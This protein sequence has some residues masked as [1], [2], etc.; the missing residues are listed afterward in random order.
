M[1]LKSTVRIPPRTWK[2]SP[3]MSA[4]L[5]LRRLLTLANGTVCLEEVR[6]KVNI[7]EVARDTLNRVGEG[8]NVDTTHK[9][10]APGGDKT[11][12]TA[13]HT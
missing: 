10:A 12:L 4:F 5:S 7:E 2:T 13:C 3:A 9:P 8:K 11:G 6:L 1:T